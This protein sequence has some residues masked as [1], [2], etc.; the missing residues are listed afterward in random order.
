LSTTALG[1][2]EA[3]LIAGDPHGE[4]TLAWT[5]AHH[6]RIRKDHSPTRIRTRRP[7]FAA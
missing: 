6:G 7:R 3:G 5:V 1:R 4:L 2:L